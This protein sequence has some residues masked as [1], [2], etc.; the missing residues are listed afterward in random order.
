MRTPS[1]EANRPQ[2]QAMADFTSANGFRANRSAEWELRN[3]SMLCIADIE[4]FHRF[5]LP[6]DSS[7]S[8]AGL[9]WRVR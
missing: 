3:R 2:P 8:S 4:A 9:Q 5:Y 1:L 7:T 6:N